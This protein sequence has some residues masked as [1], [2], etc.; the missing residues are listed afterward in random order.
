MKEKY[1][2]PELDLIELDVLKTTVATISGGNGD[3]EDVDAGA[4][5]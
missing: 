3:G 2:K 1:M 4:L 5:D